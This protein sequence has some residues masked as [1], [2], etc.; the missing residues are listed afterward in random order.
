MILLRAENDEL[1]KNLN[2]LVQVIEGLDYLGQ[3]NLIHGD[4]KHTNILI[5]K[6][7]SN[8]IAK[9]SEFGI[10]NYV[11]NCSLTQNV[12]IFRQSGGTPIFACLEFID[13]KQ[14]EKSDGYSFAIMAAFI[15]FDIRDIL[16]L[17]YH[18]TDVVKI[19]ISKASNGMLF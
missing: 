15:L 1:Q 14:K 5:K 19:Q 8:E 10:G 3:K 12:Y 17:L 2:L 11:I 13:L 6:R 7:S 9:I 18:P 4:I 16:K